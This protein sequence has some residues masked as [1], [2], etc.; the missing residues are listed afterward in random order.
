MAEEERDDELS[1]DEETDEVS[2]KLA[3]FQVRHA[4]ILTGCEF[5][6]CSVGDN[7]Y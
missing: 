5:S 3:L 6:I 7:G 2:Q 4:F 1:S